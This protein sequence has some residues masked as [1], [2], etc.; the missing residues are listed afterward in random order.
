MRFEKVLIT[1]EL[2][3]NWLSFNKHNRSMKEKSVSLLAGE[4]KAGRWREDTGE[5]I[6]FD[7]EGSL[8]DG[9]HR[10]AAIGAAGIPVSMW[11][12][13]DVPADSFKVIDSGVKRTATDVFEINGIS[14]H[15]LL[16][17]VIRLYLTYKEGRIEAKE[18]LSSQVI[19]EECESR[20]VFW[21][22]C[23]KNCMRWYSKFRPIQSSTWGFLGAILVECN[24]DEAMEFLDALSSGRGVKH[25]GINW[26][27]DKFINEAQ[28]AAKTSSYYKIA[29]IIKMWNSIR[30]GKPLSRPRFD[31]RSEGFPKAI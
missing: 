25:E 4:M 11:V 17:S 1:P 27:R 7:S 26:L 3:Q 14:Y 6:K 20:S 21:A 23:G 10:L 24:N 13:Y 12:A 8:L 9:Q 28:S 15:N 5:T 31:P 16:P 19:L 18:R 30:S 29:I 22:E 2:A